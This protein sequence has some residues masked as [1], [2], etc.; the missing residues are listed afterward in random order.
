M[1]LRDASVAKIFIRN[2]L[3]CRVV[4]TKNLSHPMDDDLPMGTP[5][6]GQP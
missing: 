5:G 3:G 2:G 4:T 1:R 6:A